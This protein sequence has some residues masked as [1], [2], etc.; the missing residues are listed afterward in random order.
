MNINI[1][2]LS[3]GRRVELVKCFK[4]A[5]NSLKI[6]SNIITADISETAP[7][8][9]FGD[10]NYIIPRIG[11]E[12]YIDSIIDI[13]KEEE[14]KLIVPTIDTELSILSQ[15]KE[16]IEEITEAK[17]LISSREVINICRN[18]INTSM[19]FE[20]NGFGIPRLIND[21]NLSAGNYKFPLFIK[22]LDGSSSINTFKINNRLQ[23]DFFIKYVKNPII[24]EFIEGKEYTID[25]FIDFDGN[26]ITIVPRE[27]I[28]TRSGEI[29]KG[30]IVKDR[31]LIEEI[32]EVISVLKPIGH[33]TFQCMKTRDG[34]KFIE[35]NPRFGGGAPMTIKAGAN[36][37]MNLY[38]LLMGEK[39]TYNE[40][41]E[42]NM[43]AL[44]FD[45]SIFINS[46]G[47]L[48]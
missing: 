3:A 27:R 35:I 12:N 29:S 8:I 47:Q 28:A 24:Q 34:I 33:I 42:D 19:F 14:I 45:D 31:D 22:P 44:R 43:I 32:K 4:D 46:E 11:E 39:L 7:A 9:Y 21:Y 40:D 30:K 38:K 23:L 36:S 1:L 41:Y 6:N 5:A 18:K 17:V 37:P 16:L 10:K 15:N 25:A 48:V 26:P 20:K 2:I 13:C